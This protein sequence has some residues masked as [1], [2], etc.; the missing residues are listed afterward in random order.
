MRGP[1][2]AG[3]RP[4]WSRPGPATAAL[5]ILIGFHLTC[6]G[7]WL[8]MDQ[9]PL[10]YDAAEHYMF[11]LTSH[12]ELRNVLT[13]DQP[14]NWEALLPGRWHG[15][16]VGLV[17]AGMMFLVGL[18]EDA[19]VL[20]ACGLFLP[21]LLLAV[22]G[23]GLRL[24]S[25]P[26]GLLA[27]AL[28]SVSPG[29]TIHQRLFL[30]D[31]P[32]AAMVALSLYLLLA[33]EGL[34]RRG[35]TILFLL[36]AGLGLSVKVNFALFVAGP[37]AVVLASR[38][39]GF[40]RARSR[41][42]AGR[43][44]LALALPAAALLLA[45][46]C[47][48]LLQGTELGH[49]LGRVIG[50]RLAALTRVPAGELLVHWGYQLLNIPLHFIHQSLS[51]LL[52][53][54]LLLGARFVFPLWSVRNA[55]LV[56]PLLCAGL[57]FFFFSPPDQAARYLLPSLGPLAVLA[58]GGLLALGRPRRPAVG[59]VL[60]LGLLQ[61]VAISFPLDIIP[62]LVIEDPAGGRRVFDVVF[63]A[64]GRRMA[65]M[66]IKDSS[67]P[68][69]TPWRVERVMQRAARPLA[70]SRRTVV[71]ALVEHPR[72]LYPLLRWEILNWE[73]SNSTLYLLDVYMSQRHQ[74]MALAHWP[75]LPRLPLE[76]DYLLLE[77]GPRSRF[78]AD[79][80]PYSLGQARRLRGLFRRHRG[81]FQRA[82]VFSFPGGVRVELRRRRAPRPA[83]DRPG[84][85]A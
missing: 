33:S 29:V 56:L 43:R 70:G 80:V 14:L 23:L 76:A 73:R 20:A 37:L 25:R 8:V 36:A 61:F 27:A 82:G 28:V 19:A 2:A 54:A 47:W 65:L 59:A 78:D 60:A 4:L 6:T 51:F 40:W 74:R 58:A 17:T 38:A 85:A 11:G 5:L 24:V 22:Y 52:L 30:L 10:I 12:L 7:V 64:R 63:F 68:T 79:K 69:P 66:N 83:G 1:T 48:A 50:D 71:V 16:L 9:L 57:F 18:E 53:L 46:G 77:H 31:L 42:A 62:E 3:E 75:P 26:A 15:A 72:L 44:W 21:I 55:Y 84:G 49:H 35:S 32:L 34:R 81:A 13:T 45:A 67:R 41:R 39:R